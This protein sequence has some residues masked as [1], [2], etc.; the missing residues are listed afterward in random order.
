MSNGHDP[1]ATTGAKLM[2]MAQKYPSAQIASETGRALASARRPV[3]SLSLC[4]WIAA[5]D[6]QSIRSLGLRPV[7][8]TFG[9]RPVSVLVLG[10][11]ALHTN[12][13]AKFF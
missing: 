10:G 1:N 3:N 4:E 12:S 11:S 7:R 8:L 6:R 13:K 2:S 5:S 9:A